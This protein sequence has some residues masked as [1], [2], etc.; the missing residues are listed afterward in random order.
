MDNQTILIITG[1]ILVF[2]LGRLMGIFET[3]RLINKIM[4]RN[5]IP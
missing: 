5:N 1:Y 4:K 2:L 3:R